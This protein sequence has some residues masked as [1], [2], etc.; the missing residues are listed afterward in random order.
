MNFYKRHI[1]DYIKDAGHLTLLEHGIYCRLLDVYYTREQSI[2]DDKASRLIGARGKDELQALR[3]VLEEFF[4]LVDGAWIQ[5]RCER[6]I[7]VANAKAEKNR[8]NGRGGGRP[9]KNKTE[10]ETENNP[11]GFD[12]GNHVGF[13]NNLS[14]TPD[15][16]LQT[17]DQKHRV[18][19]ARETSIEV[20]PVNSEGARCTPG[21]V[22]KAMRSHGVQSQPADPRLIALAQ[23]GVTLDIVTSACAEAKR[24][25][26]GE[27]VGVGYVVAIIE[28]WA[29]EA[30]AIN[31]KGA[32][33]PAAA[34][35]ESIEAQQRQ[36]N[37]EAR[38]ILFGNSTGT[39]E[40]IDV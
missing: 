29:K 12:D 9:K 20:G 33:T 37:D 34:R 13:K 30:A 25:K 8:E 40:V 14:Q 5:D 15:S 1:G 10:T 23:Q 38:Q 17:P 35:H 6:E 18:S 28:R 24:A 7:A 26:P 2:P 3:N 16:R 11:H 39:G 21:D 27:S 22:S 36:A 32:R 31:A 4:S 19:T